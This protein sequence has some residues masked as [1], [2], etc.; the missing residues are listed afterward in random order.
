M[1][2]AHVYKSSGSYKME[3][4][5]ENR[6]RGESRGTRLRI[7]GTNPDNP[8]KGRIFVWTKMGWFE[9]LEGE[10]GDVAFTPVAHSENELSEFISRND[11][12]FHLAPLGRKYRKMVS[13][14]FLEQSPYHSASPEYQS[15]ESSDEDDEQ[16]HQHDL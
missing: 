1:R 3:E 4:G 5:S 6:N 14:E 8:E 11:P 15:E 10:S 7:F 16:Y 9:R 2:L 12:S 13:E